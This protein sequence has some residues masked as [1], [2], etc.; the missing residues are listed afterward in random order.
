LSVLVSPGLEEVIALSPLGNL[1][2]RAVGRG[3]F[4]NGNLSS[5]SVSCSLKK[6]PYKSA[7]SKVDFP[8][9]DLPAMA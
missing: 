6:F 4:R 7:L 8:T 1:A 2:V 3:R 9:L 5:S